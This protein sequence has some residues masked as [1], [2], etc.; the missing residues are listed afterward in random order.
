MGLDIKEIQYLAG[1]A[2]VDIT[3]EI[4]THYQKNVRRKQTAEKIKKAV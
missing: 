2:S 3:L 1:H 4:Y